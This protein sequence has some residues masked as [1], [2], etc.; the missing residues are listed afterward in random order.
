MTRVPRFLKSLISLLENT[1]FT[2]GLI[3]MLF[4]ALIGFIGPSIYNVNPFAIN[5]PPNLPP[6]ENLPLGSD[7]LGRDVLAQLL[8]SIRG[9]LIVGLLASIISIVIAVITGVISAVFGGLV[10]TIMM[11]LSDI[12]LLIPSLL[13]M[14]IIA[15]YLPERTLYHVALVIG[16]VSWPGF[17]KTIRGVVLSVIN[18]DYIS[19]AIL[20]GVP[21]IKLVFVDVVPLVA[22]YIAA[23][24]ALLFS[25]TVLTEAA[26]SIIGLGVGK[27]CTLGL[28]LY[29]AQTYFAI[30]YGFWWT[31]I[32]TSLAIVFM[33]MSF[34]FIA[35]GL[36]NLVFPILGVSKSG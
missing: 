7:P 22:P 10:D 21:K 1:Y 28:M 27:E 19:M 2:L 16:I 26:L 18:S 3:G 9:S 20:S 15:S 4:F 5:Y 25:R 36:E 14:I 31:F 13:L 30:N 12:L 29:I 34:Y 6:R 17:A 35:I 8:H 32:P 11:R 23:S 24:F 33:S